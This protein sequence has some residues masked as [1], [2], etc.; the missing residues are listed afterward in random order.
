MKDYD[1]NKE[2]RYIRYWH[3]NNY[4]AGQCRKTFQ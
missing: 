1:K 3:V 2:S 4:M